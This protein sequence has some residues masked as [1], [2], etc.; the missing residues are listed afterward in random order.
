M[1]ELKN[2]C[3]GYDGVEVL[4]DISCAFPPGSCWCVLGSNGCGK[5]TLMR[6]M[7]GLIPHRG[8]VLLE[9][10]E[11]NG[12]KR[13]ELAV[14]AVTALVGAPFFAYVYFGRRRRERNA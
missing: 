14:G 10:R 9:G 12:M 6:T 13:R 1:L 7:A 11:I 5:T 8:Q 2:V 4:H 3:A